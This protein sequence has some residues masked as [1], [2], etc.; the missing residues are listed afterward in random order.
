MTYE[1]R[2]KYCC[3]VCG[4]V[5]DEDGRIEH[6]KGCYTQ[7]ENGGG[8]SY[9]ELPKEEKLDMSWKTTKEMTANEVR[10]EVIKRILTTTDT[11]LLEAVLERLVDSLP[12]DTL[13]GYNFKIV[14]TY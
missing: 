2:S 12:T 7:D 10:G 3:D 11:A 1:E 9:V 5:P 8:T 14:E 4:N 6:G 13:L